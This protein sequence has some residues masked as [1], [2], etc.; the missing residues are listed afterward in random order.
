MSFA[1]IKTNPDVNKI[2]ISSSFKTLTED[3]A[4]Y[5]D[6]LDENDHAS[7]FTSEMANNEYLNFT[8]F[9][10]ADMKTFLMAVAGNNSI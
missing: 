4:E 9:I 7:Y 3:W 1:S 6:Q 2:R 5:M 10:K 8:R